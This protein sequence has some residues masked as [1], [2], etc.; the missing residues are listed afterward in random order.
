L[1]KEARR[2]YE[3]SLRRSLTGI[4]EAKNRGAPMHTAIVAIEMPKDFR[5][6]QW[7]RSLRSIL[8]RVEEDPAIEQLAQNVWQVNFV[9]SP[10][11]FARLIGAAEGNNLAYRILP[12]DSEPKWIRWNPTSKTS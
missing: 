8:S 12:L 1:C 4:A 6:D 11:G 5:E 2:Q 9:K 10:G 3:R 7:L